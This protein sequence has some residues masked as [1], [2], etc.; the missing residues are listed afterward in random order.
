MFHA[1]R[2]SGV[3]LGLFGQAVAL[4][5]ML[6]A[7]AA[8]AAETIKFLYPW[9]KVNKANYDVAQDIAKLIK[10]KSGGELDVKVFNRTVV[11]PFKQ[12][13]PVS[14]GAFDLHYTSTAYH[15]GATAIG[16]LGDTIAPDP[17]KRRSSGL[18]DLVDKHYQK[19]QKL[20]VLGWTGS[21]GYQILLKKP[22]GPDGGLKGL[23]IRG[24][25]AYEPII[26]AM[27]GTTV[28]LPAPQ[29]YT[30]LQKNLIDG[31]A[32]VQ[33]SMVERKFYEVVKYMARPKF[34]VSTNI[35]VMNLDRFNKLSPKM[36][37]VM[38]DVGRAFDDIAPKYPRENAVYNENEMQ[39]KGVKFTKF[40]DQYVSK[41]N[42][43]Y[44]NGV[45]KR[46]VKQHGAEA[47]AIIKL[48]KEK[49]LVQSEK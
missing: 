12:L 17:D 36:Q 1:S 31:A 30:A 35:L 25:P 48:A 6:P 46:I 21:P 38:L 18:F 37:K 20:K 5:V 34:G 43:L 29:I 7:G 32:W 39:K 24:N 13:Q 8:S 33:H 3:R 40:G 41:I 44:N 14:A 47:E 49:N 4:A 27:G 22:V 19:T 2:Q 23:K 16:Q 11:P 26:S 42:D 9:S 28:T 15:A 10:E 45:W